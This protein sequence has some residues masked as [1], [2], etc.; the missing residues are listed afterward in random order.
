M[1]TDKLSNIRDYKIIPP[2]AIDKIVSGISI[3]RHNIS[4][5]CYINVE[6]YTTKAVSDA[7][8]EA[9]KKYIDVQILLSGTEDIYY[10]VTKNLKNIQTPYNEERDI[11]FYSENVTNYDKVT[12][13]GTNFV[14]LEPEDAHA[15]QAAHD[16][17]QQNVKKVVIKIRK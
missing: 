15:P 5:S 6:E 12:L 13:D 17:K 16:N 8:F 4:D 14:I 2:E 10:T 11:M 9:H 7:K 3:G 1:I